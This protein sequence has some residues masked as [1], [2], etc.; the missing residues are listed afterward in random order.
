M[1]WEYKIFKHTTHSYD[2]DLMAESAQPYFAVHEI[3]R[4]EDGSIFGRNQMPD[5]PIGDSKEE[6]IAMLEQMLTD[7]RDAE[8]LV[9][10]FNYAPCKSEDELP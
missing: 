3:Y 5:G 8:V 10:P 1:T 6:L 7:C 2:G 9:E 4:N